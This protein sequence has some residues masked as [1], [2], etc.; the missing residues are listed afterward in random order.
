MDDFGDAVTRLHVPKD[1]KPGA[2]E[3]VATLPGG[4]SSTASL[5]VT[6]DVVPGADL[7]LKL[8][9]GTVYAGGDFT[10]FVASDSAKPGT[11][12]VI[13][14]PGGKA[15]TTKINAHGVA[16]VRFHVSSGTKAGAYVFSAD[17]ERAKKVYATLTVKKRV[18]AQADGLTPR[19]GAETGGGRV[20]AQVGGGTGGFGGVA[21]GGLLMAAGAGA[22]FLGRRRRDQV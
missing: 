5:T 10:A 1:A 8:S 14:D 15:V 2:Y 7:Y 12:V 22:A 18:V 11:E 3:V 6:Q 16:A 19:G 20:A 21:V 17:M 9:P 4:Q 13:A